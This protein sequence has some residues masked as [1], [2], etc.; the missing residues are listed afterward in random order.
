M[1]SLNITFADRMVKSRDDLL[2][3]LHAHLPLDYR[4]SLKS[5]LPVEVRTTDAEG[6]EK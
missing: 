6:G 3:R 2:V 5:C 1:V 4:L